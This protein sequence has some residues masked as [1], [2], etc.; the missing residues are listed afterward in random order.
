MH[1]QIINLAIIS[2]H[3][4]SLANTFHDCLESMRRT[5]ADLN[6]RV[7][8][9][10]NTF[11]EGAINILWGVGTHHSKDY[12]SIDEYAKKYTTAFVN[13]EQLTS[14]SILVD[15]EYTAMIS[16]FP[17]ID[18]SPVNINLINSINEEKLNHRLEFPFIPYSTNHN[19]DLSI[20][21]YDF[22]FVGAINQRRL[23]LLSKL[24]DYGFKIK[25]ISNKYKNELEQTLSDCKALLNIHYY[26]SSIF[27][28]A[29]CLK[30]ASMGIPILSEESHMPTEIDWMEAG[31]KFITY[32]TDFSS[33]NDFLRIE[34]LNS[35]NLKN[36]EF[37]NKSKLNIDKSKI[38]NFIS[39]L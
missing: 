18:Y 4:D 23:D 2:N 8:I 21:P 24:S 10:K 35:L 12:A 36:I 30:P 26:E 29:R 11:I 3:P 32:T 27:E 17:L 5:L 19:Y 31:I 38:L 33:Y 1:N 20:R 34:N 14:D 39:S 37:C 25:I 15:D 22:A 28:I 7:L 6:F 13:L 9:T 16:K